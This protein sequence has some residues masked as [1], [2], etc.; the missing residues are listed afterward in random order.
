LRDATRKPGKAPLGEVTV[1]QV[2]ALTCAEPPGEATH[3]TGRA[4][5]IPIAEAS[6]VTLALD[7]WVLREACLQ[8]RAWQDRG[9]PLRVAINL[10]QAQS[11][12]TSCSESTTPPSRPRARPSRSIAAMSVDD[13]VLWQLWPN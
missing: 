1:R 8:A 9:Q 7:A 3:W 12:A 13:S 2:V 10:S 11:S 4:M 5:A 6:G